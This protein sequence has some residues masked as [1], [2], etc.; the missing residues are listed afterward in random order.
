MDLNSYI[1]K[2][3]LKAIDKFNE[4]LL[5]FAEET[6]E[7]P[8]TIYED[9]FTPFTLSNIRVENGVMYWEQDGKVDHC[10]IVLLDD[11]T[12]EYYEDDWLDGIPQSLRYWK[13]CLRK[14]KKYWSMSSEDLDAIYDERKPDIADEDGEY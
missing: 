7:N 3:H 11:E 1:K 4:E 6:G 2:S 12:N 9:M 13:S 10:N 5:A 14:A 8:P